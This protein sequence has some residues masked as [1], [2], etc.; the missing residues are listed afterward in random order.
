MDAKQVE[1]IQQKLSPLWLNTREDVND[2][3]LANIL[4]IN[5]VQALMAIPLIVTGKFIGIISVAQRQQRLW[6][7]SDIEILR[8]I[9]SQTA[10]AINNLYLFQRVQES[11]NRWQ[12]TFDSMTDGVAL[13]SRENRVLDANKAL[14]RLCQVDDVQELLGHCADELF[15]AHDGQAHSYSA[16]AMRTATNYQ[17]ELEDRKGRVLRQNI[18][19]IV[20]EHYHV[21]EL[22]LVVRNVTNERRAEQEMAQRNR[23]LSILNAI[24][25]EITR[26]LEID[27]II[28]SAFGYVVEL[29]AVEVGFV[30]LLDEKQ[31]QLQPVAYRGSLPE[32]FLAKLDNLASYREIV[33][34]I[35]ELP[36]PLII[37]DVPAAN[38]PLRHFVDL[39]AQ[40]GVQSAMVTKLKSKNHQLGVM[41]IAFRQKRIFAES[42]VRLVTAVG[43]QVGVAVENARL[44]ANLQE[45]LEELREANRLKDEF[46]AT[47]SHE[48]RTP[49]T[50][51]RGWAELLVEREELDDEMLTGLQSILNNSEALQQLIN[52]LLELSRIE[53]RMLKLELEPSDI[54][55][56]IMA[57]MQ[58]VKQMADDRDIRL[59]QDL[60]LELPK[61]SLDTNRL[62]QVFWNLLVNGIKFSRPQGYVRITT[63]RV[64][65]FVEILVADN[66]IG[67][68]ASFLPL[69]FE[70]FRQAD[71]SSTRRYGGLGIGL[72]LVKSLVE[73]HNGE[74]RAESAGRNQGSTFTIRLPIPSPDAFTRTPNPGIR[75][76]DIFQSDKAVALIIEDLEDNL[77]LLSS[78]IE[79]SGYQVLAVRSTEAGLRLAER[80]N[81][82]LILLDINMPGRG[83]QELLHLF[84]HREELATTPVLAVSSFV[85]ESERQQI[86]SIGF[87]GLIT[88]PFRRSEIQDLIKRLAK[89]RQ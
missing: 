3:V 44:I 43:R 74:V 29:M 15:I 18:D 11:Q 38:L 6:R 69:V 37:A 81:P 45:A 57:A 35:E 22:V 65:N 30:L 72:S 14:L 17:V 67:I 13:V 62:Q 41:I 42:E 40:M 64:D 25:E 53:N 28:V 60:S 19:P 39:A 54:N 66:G 32:E 47:L 61:L 79:R 33:R 78:V 73:A 87:D 12:R 27:K 49:L 24:A 83:P 55:L 82:H 88:K 23:Q 16:E 63:C 5:D 89:M 4:E 21:S 20:D 68:D 8:V 75:L 36:D 46:L 1:I 80:C 31:E 10:V 9:A 76:S 7:E 59:E 77:R 85:N 50:S 71:S 84:R 48:L 34:T 51:I 56:V 70:R 2:P 86:L 58:T 52:D 26:S